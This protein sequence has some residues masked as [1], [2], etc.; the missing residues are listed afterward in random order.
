VALAR[1]RRDDPAEREAL[2]ALVPLLPTGARLAALLRLSS[3]ALAAGDAALARATAEEA[4]ALA[5]R[6]AAAVEACRVAA[7]A[8]GDL[9]RVAE[10][11]GD[12]AALEPAAAGPRLLDR[13]RLLASLAD[14]EGADA[15]YA[16]ALAALPADRALADEHARHR[17]ARLGGRAAAEPLEAFAL[18][19]PD[20]REGAAALRVAAAEALAGGDLGVALR[21]A[22]RAYART[23]EDL[24]FAAP[25]LG[26]VLYLLGARAE[27][28]VLH[29]RLLEAD[30]RGV[31]PEE[32]IALCR[33][34]AELAEDEG[35]R[36]VALAAYDRLL[37]LR[38]ADL[39]AALRR[40]ELDP[41]RARAA[42][43]LARAAEASRSR[44]RRA[45][46]LA[47][48]AAAAREGSD[49]ELGEALF[50]RAREDAAGDA[51]LATAIARRRAEV[52]RAVEGASS[53]AFLAAL[54]DAAAAAQ[55]AGDR[56]AA[57]ELL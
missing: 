49:R 39:D 48:A 52:I 42:R 54:H 11:L 1:G 44:R 13:A 23:Q 17:R 53:G 29:R 37:A 57:R 22:R 4:R 12:L 40:F 31:A 47:R 18:R 46:A 14:A 55:G 15:A 19:A 24:A 6:D 38:P 34:A 30:F 3:L 7:L 16:G 33:E 45:L 28:L 20:R 50:A 25:L 51:A 56:A 26:R 8:G 36:D 43:D 5:P 21:C 32:A 10:L 9:A 27:A 35:E 2:A 41:D